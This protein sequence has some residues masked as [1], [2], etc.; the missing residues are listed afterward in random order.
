MFP[1]LKQNCFVI[2]FSLQVIQPNLIQH[3]QEAE[4]ILSQTQLTYLHDVFCEA[5]RSYHRKMV[6]HTVSPEA[7]PAL[8][9]ILHVPGFYAHYYLAESP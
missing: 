4:S 9:Y 7:A 8:I 3:I 2:L 6:F 1:P 5:H